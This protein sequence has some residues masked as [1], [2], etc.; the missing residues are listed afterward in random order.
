MDFWSVVR[1]EYGN[2][3]SVAGLLVSLAGF[4]LT[5]RTVKQAS[6]RGHELAQRAVERVTDRL[7]FTLIRNAL[8]L[9]EEIRQQVHFR[10]WDRAIDRAEQLVTALVSLSENQQLAAEEGV[11]MVAMIDDAGLIKRQ[12]EGMPTKA[13]GASLANQP[14]RVTCVRPSNASRQ[15]STLRCRQLECLSRSRTLVIRS[16]SAGRYR[17]HSR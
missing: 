13:P 11:V 6:K 1:A 16:P 8:R 2:A 4:W 9:A 15:G 12:I 14:R 3:A 17:E 5:I 10:N 7:T